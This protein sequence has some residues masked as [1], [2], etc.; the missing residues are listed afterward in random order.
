MIDQGPYLLPK[1]PKLPCV[2]AY[3]RQLES[4][5]LTVSTNPEVR[6]PHE[7]YEKISQNEQRGNYPEA[8]GARGRVI[9]TVTV[10]DKDI[11]ERKKQ[12]PEAVNRHPRVRGRKRH[13]TKG[14]DNQE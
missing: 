14:T 8:G 6:I 9:G 11:A 1:P 4:D 7:E 13:L 12:T 3:P 10:S 5:T 2:P